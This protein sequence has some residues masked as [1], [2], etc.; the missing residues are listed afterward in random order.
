MNGGII[1]KGGGIAKLAALPSVAAPP[2]PAV[3]LVVVVPAASDVEPAFTA[4]N[5]KKENVL[6]KWKCISKCKK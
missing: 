6:L 1:M 2:T 4:K 3:V 5:K